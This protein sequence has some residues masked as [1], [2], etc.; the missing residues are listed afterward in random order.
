MD[1]YSVWC[2]GTGGRSVGGFSYQILS[3]IQL[4]SLFYIFVLKKGTDWI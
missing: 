4:V 2:G 1:K 3:I